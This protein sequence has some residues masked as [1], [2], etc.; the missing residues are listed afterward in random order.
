MNHGEAMLKIDSSKEIAPRTPIPNKLGKF[1]GPGEIGAAEYAKMFG[2]S[3]WTAWVNLR[4]IHEQYGDTVVQ[5]RGGRGTY[6]TTPQALE[7]IDSQPAPKVKKDNRK[8]LIS[9]AK[10]AVATRRETSALYAGNSPEKS[11]CRAQVYVRLLRNDRKGFYQKKHIVIASRECGDIRFLLDI[12]VSPN[13]II[14]CD[15]DPHAR[16]AAQV[17]LPDENIG[18]DIVETVRATIASGAE[19]STINID[20]CNKLQ[21]GGK[22]L[23]DILEL[24]K[25]GGAANAAVFLTYFCGRDN[26]FSDNE[27][28]ACLEGYVGRTLSPNDLYR[29]QSWTAIRGGGSPMCIAIVAENK[30]KVKE[31]EHGN[32][33]KDRSN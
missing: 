17:H 24:T 18:T 15:T 12:G 6:V 30:K 2:V 5:R 23:K 13:N 19:I 11:L 29:Y 25:N 1:C 20:L 26:M 10:K 14:A 32:S 21:V 33:K 4:T 28:K 3:R 31:K 7:L 22:I 27:R 9:A 16:L 8:K